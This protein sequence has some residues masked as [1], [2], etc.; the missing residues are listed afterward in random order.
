M[1]F[2]ALHQALGRQPGPINSEMLD[3]AIENGV[4]EADG[5]DWKRDLPA[6]LRV[7]TLPPSV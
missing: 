7:T 5:L 3:E 4:D 1:T 2:T 6:A